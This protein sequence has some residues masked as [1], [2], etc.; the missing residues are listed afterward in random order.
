MC[1]GREFEA[2]LSLLEGMR[3]WEEEAGMMLPGIAAQL[4]F[5]L[6][7]SEALESILPWPAPV[8]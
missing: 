5:L 7:S 6:L 1:G 3:L 8:R 4:M 2:V